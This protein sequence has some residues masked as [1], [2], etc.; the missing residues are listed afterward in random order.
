MILNIAGANKYQSVAMSGAVLPFCLAWTVLRLAVIDVSI[1]LNVVK[2]EKYWFDRV[3]HLIDLVFM[4]GSR[5][6]QIKISRGRGPLRT[7]HV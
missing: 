2:H 7:L 3:S 6:T 4:R 5:T 1:F